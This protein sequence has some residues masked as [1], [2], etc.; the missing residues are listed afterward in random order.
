[1]ANLIIPPKCL[2]VVGE[3]K[4]QHPDPYVQN[5]GIH[6]SSRELTDLQLSPFPEITFG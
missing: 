1:M 2:R 6:F 5:Q 4:M 3:D